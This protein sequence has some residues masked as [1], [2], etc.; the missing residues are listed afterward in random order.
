MNKIITTIMIVTT[1]ATGCTEYKMNHCNCDNMPQ[2]KD[3]G[4]IVE[5]VILRRFNQD[6]NIQYTFPKEFTE[7]KITNDQE[8]EKY[9]FMVSFDNG[10]SFKPIDFNKYSILGYPISGSSPQTFERDVI[11]EDANHKYIYKINAITCDY[12][13]DIVLD[14]N[15]VLIP[16]IEDGY[17]TEFVINYVRWQNGKR[18]NVSKEKW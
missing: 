6:P 1:I 17:T 8:N 15:I 12:F 9:N 5:N 11:K 14:F 4:I 7:L 13:M 16:K 10:V 3:S 2:S 18:K